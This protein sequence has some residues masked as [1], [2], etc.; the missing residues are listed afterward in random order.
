MTFSC[1]RRWRLRLHKQCHAGDMSWTKRKST[2]KGKCCCTA[3]SDCLQLNSSS[4]PT[5]THVIF[6]NEEHKHSGTYTISD[7]FGWL[8]VSRF[9]L[10]ILGKWTRQRSEKL[11]NYKQWNCHR[12]AAI[13][14]TLVNYIIYKV[15]S[16][17]ILR[18]HVKKFLA[19]VRWM[20]WVLSPIKREFDRMSSIRPL[21]RKSRLSPKILKIP[22]P[23]RALKPIKWL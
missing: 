6:G 2:R 7:I 17:R 16:P 11:P 22:N 9:N 4:L 12:M 14:F 3:P 15:D 13:S 10:W 23:L 18:V 8:V 20:N 1:T 21:P 5:L 19:Y